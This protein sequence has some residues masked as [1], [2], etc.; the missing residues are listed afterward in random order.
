[1]NLVVAYLPGKS[2][3]TDIRSSLL[4]MLDSTASIFVP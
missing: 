3:P 1:M 4:V 2:I